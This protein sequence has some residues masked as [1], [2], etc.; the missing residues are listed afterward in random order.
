M[1]ETNFHV[2]ADNFAF[3]FLWKKLK[4]MS[5]IASIPNLVFL[6]QHP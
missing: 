2:F 5:K 4:I 1:V 6:Q 3:N